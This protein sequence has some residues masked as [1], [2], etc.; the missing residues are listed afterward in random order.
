MFCSF[1]EHSC[2][3]VYFN[4]APPTFLGGLEHSGHRVG[5]YRGQGASH[6]RR[7]PLALTFR[8]P[9]GEQRNKRGLKRKEEVGKLDE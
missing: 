8:E 5:G 6:R 9:S 2:D 7:D 3:C 1:D 4:S